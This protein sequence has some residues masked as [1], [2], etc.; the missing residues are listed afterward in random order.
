MKVFS[1]SLVIIICILFC[2]P[3][4]QSI[5]GLGMSFSFSKYFTVSFVIAFLFFLKSSS[6]NLVWLSTFRHELVHAIVALLCLKKVDSF[7]ANQ[8][9]NGHITY[10]G[11]G[12]ILITLSPYFLPIFSIV[13]LGVYMVASIT[14]N[15]IILILLGIVLAFEVRSFL[16]DTKGHQPDLNQNGVY[17]SMC[18]IVMMN[19]MIS[20]TIFYKIANKKNSAIYTF[21]ANVKSEISWAVRKIN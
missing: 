21:Y 2:K 13:T 3:F 5:Y 14:S 6:S 8:S 19:L 15:P 9:G 4:I 17:F 10:F 1:T 12:N 18:F 20:S 11:R 16:S 7:N